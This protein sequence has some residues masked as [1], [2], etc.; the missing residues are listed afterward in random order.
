M[1]II[2]YMDYFQTSNPSINMIDANEG[3]MLKLKF[4]W[5]QH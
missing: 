3:E 2:I 1:H 4:K 5:S